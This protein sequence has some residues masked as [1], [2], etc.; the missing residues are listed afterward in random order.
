MNDGAFAFRVAAQFNG[1]P[2]VLEIVK[3]LS[4]ALSPFE[5]LKASVPELIASTGGTSVTVRAT[6]TVCGLLLVPLSPRAA[7]EIVPLYEPGERAEDVTV[8]VKVALPLVR[9]AAEGDTAN[10]PVP[11]VVV[12]VGVI[13]NPLEHDPVV[14]I[15]RTWAAGSDPTLAL[16]VSLA[17]EGADN[18]QGVCAAVDLDRLTTRVI[19]TCA[20][21]P[22]ELIV[23]EA[24]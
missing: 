3:V 5:R 22:L 17:E 21:P 16:K 24:D 23:S 4:V 7:S 2:P 19:A 10:Q 6:L 13:V 12:T 18:V 20:L 15:V 14:P 1:A 8:T 9:V 11:D